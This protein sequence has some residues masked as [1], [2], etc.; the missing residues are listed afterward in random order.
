VR[1]LIVANLGRFPILPGIVAAI[2]L[3]GGF[4]IVPA[5]AWWHRRKRELKRV[6]KAPGP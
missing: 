3:P 6:L 4:V 1:A 5:V 2:L